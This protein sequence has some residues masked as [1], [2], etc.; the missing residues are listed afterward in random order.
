[1]GDTISGYSN[2]DTV[3][4]ANTAAHPGDESRITDVSPKAAL[5]DRACVLFALCVSIAAG[6][7][8]TPGRQA[9][10]PR[11]LESRAEPVALANVRYV[12]GEAQDMQRLR[13]EFEDSWARERDWL[14]SQGRTAR[15][16]P[17]ASFLAL[18]GGGDKGAFGAGLLNGWSAT[19]KRPTFKLVTGIS[20][21]ALI[22]PFAFL[23]P[24][25]DGKLKAFYTNSTRDDLIRMRSLIAALTDDAI[26]DTAPLRAMLKK[27]IDRSFLDAIAAEHAKGRE[28]WVSTTNLDAN[29]RVIWNMTRIASS[30]DPRALDLFHDVMIASA[31]IPGAFPPVM[32]DVQLDGKRYQEMH[33]DGG[34]T[35]QVF[36]YP[37]DF[38]LAKLAREH[39]GER[40]RSVYIVVNNRID[41]EWAQ[42]ERR[43]ITIAERAI[44]SLIHTQGIG[45]LYRIYLTA[46]NDGMDFNLAYIPPDFTQQPGELFDMSFMRA[47]F[48]TG[49]RMGAQEGFWKKHPPDFKADAPKGR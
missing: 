8:A 14:R 4:A 37:P 12:V 24:Q 25:Y 23:G 49:S 15:E 11:N 34:A 27:S 44:T 18:S 46:M 38:D 9:A 22:A 30:R 2:L 10:V 26:A 6:G 32:I 45:D 43:A 31:A 17:P 1:M 42:T 39:D 19:G 40:P 5:I 16:L 28:L 35:A 48:E 47:L 21:G 13:Q 36:V 20:T 41:A 29:R 33:V 7:C 3:A